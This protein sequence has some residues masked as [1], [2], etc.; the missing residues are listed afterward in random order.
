MTLQLLHSEFP[1]IWGKFD[2]L[3]YQCTMSDALWLNSEHFYDWREPNLAAME[4]FLH[5]DWK[6]AFIW[7]NGFIPEEKRKI[8]IQQIREEY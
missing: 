6:L 8:D 5:L 2:F 7:T 3:F 1:Y 4:S